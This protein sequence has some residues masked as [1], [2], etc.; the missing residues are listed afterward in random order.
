[1]F[2]ANLIEGEFNVLFIH[3]I[4][5]KHWNIIKDTINEELAEQVEKLYLKHIDE[6]NLINPKQF[7]LTELEMMIECDYRSKSNCISLKIPA[8]EIELLLAIHQKGI[9]FTKLERRVIPKTTTKIIKEVTK[10][11]GYLF[12]HLNSGMKL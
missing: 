11:Q 1:M 6:N 10:V 12:L 3:D 8:K 2:D 5:S 4:T 7:S 9:N